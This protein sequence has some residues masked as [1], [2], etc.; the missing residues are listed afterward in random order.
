MS[1]YRTKHILGI[2]P[3]T[4]RSAWACY[5]PDL[6][7][8]VF[9]AIL[10]N[11]EMIIRLR[12]QTEPP[13][14]LLAIEMIQ[15][16]GMSVGKSVFETCVW[17]GRFIEAWH[18]EHVRINRLAV[19]QAICHDSRAKDK[20]IRQALIDMFP[21]IGGGKV[22][23]I[24]TKAQMGPLYGFKADMWQALAVAITAKEMENA[25]LR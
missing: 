14:P 9:A 21:T 22:P 8:V 10:D 11:E 3:G 12:S 17:V 4:T 15:S 25:K 7:Q 16:Y 2:D 1:N 19:K 5:R 6:H 24:G 13:L 23:Q 20:N 18:G